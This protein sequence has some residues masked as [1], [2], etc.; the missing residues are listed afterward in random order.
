MTDISALGIKVTSNGVVKTTG[1]LTGF[2]KAATAARQAASRPIAVKIGNTGIAKALSDIQKLDSALKGMGGR[3]SGNTAQLKVTGGAA[4]IKEINRF[5]NAVSDARTRVGS[6]ITVTLRANGGAAAIKEIHEYQNAVNQTQAAA[7]RGVNFRMDGSGAFTGGAIGGTAGVV[8]LTKSIM[9]LVTALGVLTAGRFFLKVADESNLIAA[10]M[11]LATAANGSFAQA[12]VD[13]RNIAASSRSDLEVTAMLYQRL[14]INSKQLGLAQSEVAR[15]TETV[16]KSFKISGAN[17]VE[18]TQGTRQLIQALQS[19]VL[20]GDEFNTIMEAAPRI[21]QALLDSLNKTGKGAIVTA[22]DLRKMAESGELTGDLI[23]KA[24]LDASEAINNEFDKLPVTFGDAMGQLYNAAVI[25]FGAFD[26]GGQFST[27]I[28]QFI[29]GGTKGMGEM[30][31][32]AHQMGS[33]L[34]GEINGVSA[35]LGPTIDAMNAL[36]ASLQDTKDLTSGGLF[37]KLFEELDAITGWVSKQGLLGSLITGGSVS[38]W[39]NNKPSTGGTNLSKPYQRERSQAAYDGVMSV[40]AMQLYLAGGGVL[41]PEKIGRSTAATVANT[42]AKDN[43]AS[44]SQRLA[45]RLEREADATE[46]LIRGNYE[47]A[48]AYQSSTADGKMA[49]VAAEAAA[50]GIKARGDAQ[51]YTARELRKWVSEQ[52]VSSAENNAA[53]REQINIQKTVNKAVSEGSLSVEE[54]SIAI[55]N[56]AEQRKILNAIILAKKNKD[57]EGEKALRIELGKLTEQQIEYNAAIR[58]ANDI[59]AAY[60]ST[61]DTASIEEETKLEKRLGEERMKALRGLSGDALENEL[62]R[63]NDERERALVLLEYTAKITAATTA[64]QWE[65]VKALEAERDARLKQ[66]GQAQGQV[67]AERTFDQNRRRTLD[68][69]NDVGNII[70][71]KIGNAMQEL[72][73]TLDRIMPDLAADLGEMFGTEF[74]AFSEGA[75]LGGSFGAISGSRAGGSIGGGLG[76]IG[77]EAISGA[78][79]KLG[80]FAGP[81]G[82]IAGGLIGGL[83][84]GMLKKTPRASATVSIIAGEAMETA[85]KGSSGALKKAA[86]QMANGVIDGL[87]GLADQLGAQ[88]TGDATVSIGMRKK[89]YR[90]DPTGQGITKTSKGAIDFGEDQAA[91]IAYAMQVAIKQGVLDG[92]SESMKRLIMGDGD[93]QSQIQKALSFKGVFDDLAKRDDPAKFAQDEITRWH[94]AMAKIFEEAGATGEELA[95]L[96]RLTGIKR[97]EAAEEAAKAI[98]DANRAALDRENEIRDKRIELLEAQGKME[99]YELAMRAAQLADMPEY[100]RAIQMQINAANDLTKE[101]EK[102]AASRQEEYALMARLA[103]AQG[104]TATVTRLQREDELRSASSDLTRQYLLQIYAAE[105]LTAANEKLKAIADERFGLEGRLLELQGDTAAL[106]QRELDALDPA[107]RALLQMIFNLGDAKTA[108]DEFAAAQQ[109]MTDEIDGLNRQWLELTGQT[110]TL[111]GMDLALLK[112]DEARDIQKNI[113]AYQ[114]ALEAQKLAQEAATAAAEEYAAKL[115]DARGKLSSAYERE[116]SALQTTIDK[117]REFSASIREFRDGL[118]GSANPADGLARAQAR[119]ASTSSMARLGN[120]ASLAAFTGDAQSYLDAAQASGTYAQYQAAMAAVLGGSNNAIAGA[121]GVATMAQNQLDQMTR[122][123][124]GL[125]LLR[126]DTLTFNEALMDYQRILNEDAI[127]AFTET[128]STSIEALTEQV[129]AGNASA[130]EVGQKATVTLETVALAINLM[131]RI[132]DRAER[133]GALAVTLD[134][135]SITAIIEGVVS[136]DQI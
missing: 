80:K 102:L 28:S 47:A 116:S 35:A 108:A 117:F 68:L 84:G 115:D 56:M 130:E 61:I 32:A 113:W 49:S 127:P 24:L 42:K 59:A 129:M 104:D 79:G 27:A 69:A 132:L 94:D 81:L 128:V 98:E 66:I 121:D 3:G 12:M 92:L 106:R 126:D 38:D 14:M 110:Q 25:T 53:L 4:A 123:V 67:A 33:A 131:S 54:A 30:E 13:V 17:T 64:K 105:D 7:S 15:V 57:G 43:A 16:G 90:V 9:G 119:F 31:Y 62:A 99:E 95:A 41:P 75:K 2:A 20:R 101:E 76:Q 58:E 44:A 19:G 77:G 134:G 78:L 48:K 73:S 65:Y 50:K 39:W 60:Q 6:G 52:A 11:K 125:G 72:V 8:G 5:A 136:V 23:T 97:T 93:L 133:E 103:A 89:N 26:Q 96:E 71:G 82:A 45:E 114:D 29:I 107:N 100:L 111:R 51:I 118:L 85:I 37:G 91:A 120:E 21:Q 36:L 124:E 55:A 46:T 88:L 10:R 86:G 18:A 135:E 109:A 1:E 122:V 63:I 87:L 34:R 70:G 112:S 22:G 83:I 40:D 74:K